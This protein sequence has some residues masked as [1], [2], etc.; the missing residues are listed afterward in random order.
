LA[1]SDSQR[2]THDRE[3]ASH[4]SGGPDGA[5]WLVEYGDLTIECGDEADA[6]KL[7]AGLHN[8]G[9]LVTA[10]SFGT[11]PPKSIENVDQIKI[12]LAE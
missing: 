12:W 2:H 9:R 11:S 3:T 1:D 7:V 5:R 6:K 10:R 4:K 8:N